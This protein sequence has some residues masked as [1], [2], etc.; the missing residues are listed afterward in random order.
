MSAII[1]VQNDAGTPITSFNFGA[2]EGGAYQQAKFIAKNVGNQDAS[3]V[4]LYAQRLAANDGFD[5]V[6]IA[7]DIEG[8][9]GTFQS[10]S[11]TIGTLAA[12]AEYTFWVKV[13]IPSGTTPAGN[14]RQFDIIT[15]YS[16]T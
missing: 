4:S 9:P 12:N 10:G 2:V 13:T 7:P 6:Q 1:E 3:S 14:P 11:I 8:N 16:G 5:F 15:E